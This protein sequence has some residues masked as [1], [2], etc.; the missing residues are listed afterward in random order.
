MSK[1]NTKNS[2]YGFLTNLSIIYPE[3]ILNSKLKDNDK[4]SMPNTSKTIMAFKIEE[5]NIFYS[6]SS[7]CC[8]F[9][10]VLFYY[11][12]CFGPKTPCFEII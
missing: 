11:C 5:N 8:A 9:F 3:K 10:G 6:Q 1:L 12:R 7:F 4:T 2:F